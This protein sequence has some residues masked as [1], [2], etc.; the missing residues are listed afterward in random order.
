[1]ACPRYD[2]DDAEPGGDSTPP[3]G[4]DSGTSTTWLTPEDC[5]AGEQWDGRACVP[6]DCGL[7]P[8]GE[9][10]DDGSEV[11]WVR[12]DAPPGGDGSRS[13]PFATLEE[14]FATRV[15]RIHLGAGTYAEEVRLSGGFELWGRCRDLV[16][17]DA[18]GRRDDSAYGIEVAGEATVRGV[19]VRGADTVGILVADPGALTLRD[20]LVVDNVG[21]GILVDGRESSLDAEDIRIEGT[22]EDAERGGGIGLSVQSGALAE[23]RRA[24]LD[25][26]QQRGVYV[27]GNPSALRFED[28]LIRSTVPYA[29]GSYGHGLSVE[30][31]GVAIGTGLQVLD[32]AEAGIWVSGDGSGLD[33]TAVLVEGVSRS[34]RWDVGVGVAVLDGA[35]AELDGEV[36]ATTGPGLVVEEATLT[37]GSGSVVSDTEFAG[38]VVVDGTL[39]ATELSVAGGVA[40]ADANGGVGL[41]V[42]SPSGSGEIELRGGACTGPLAGAWLA[43][44]GS[45]ELSATTLAGVGK[46]ETWGLVLT[47]APPGGLTVSGGAITGW[48]IGV[49]LQG[50]TAR[51]DE[52]SWKGN[53]IDVAQWDCDDV[54][55]LAPDGLGV[56]VLCTGRRWDLPEPS[57][58]PLG[59]RE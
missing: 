43:G 46:R 57:W 15:R 23:V 33:A 51:I 21:I 28:L 13:A 4:D 39:V 53:A 2:G 25:D 50:S 8:W 22:V 5:E 9:L 26:N 10:E 1:L 36:L 49:A 11:V 7:Y 19:T 16:V 12:A 56:S 24:E 27:R 30:G 40:D 17:V 45:Y 20:A 38:V 52:V 14:A 31:S 34:G 54:A 48:A 32:S 37:V 58:V 44:A 6:L 41:Y 59:S 29:D 35:E 18:S 47:D 55:P 3:T 42:D